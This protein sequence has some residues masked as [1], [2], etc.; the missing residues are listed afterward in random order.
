[1]LNS[2]PKLRLFCRRIS[3]KHTTGQNLA[4]LIKSNLKLQSTTFG[5]SKTQVP[6]NRAT[7]VRGGTF[8]FCYVLQYNQSIEHLQFYHAKETPMTT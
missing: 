5:D 2:T 4:H 1:M 3:P 6:M 8:Q 7:S